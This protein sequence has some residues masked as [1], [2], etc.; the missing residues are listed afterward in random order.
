MGGHVLRFRALVR[1]FAPAQPVFALQA[2]GLSREA[3]CLNRV[4]DMAD[5]YVEEIR[6]AQR[7]G[8]YSLGGYSF[9]GLVALEIARRLKDLGQEV[10]YLALIDT[11]AGKPAT[12]NSLLRRFLRLSRD[13]K[14][15]YLSRKMRK[16][17]RRTI[18]GAAL[19]AAVKAVRQACADA[20]RSYQPRVFEG[21]ISLFL[22]SRKSLRN[23][24]AED[25]G[26]GD[27]AAQGVVVYEIPG[28]HGDIVDEPSAGELAR[29][30]LSGI[31]RARV[32]R[33]S[34]R[35]LEVMR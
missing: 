16:K 10:E 26:W 7:E 23:S 9:G 32:V 11:F 13:E 27:F 12:T 18:A 19:P 17:V 6:A 20:E 14:I 21:K 5:R 15:S 35:P 2:Q 1:H 31:K 29:L 30:I 3:P 34:R 25:G 28:D 4:E 8:P 24:T 22:P 33:P